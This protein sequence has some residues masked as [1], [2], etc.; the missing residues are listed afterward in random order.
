[1]W[2]IA[3]QKQKINYIE[4]KVITFIMEEIKPL[5]IER[6]KSKKGPSVST[7][8]TF[9]YNKAQVTTFDLAEK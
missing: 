4:I 8:M 7:V 6:C 5:E 2:N 9:Y 1:M 3:I